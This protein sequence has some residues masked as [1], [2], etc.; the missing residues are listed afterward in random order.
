MKLYK[1][2][3][4]TM[5]WLKIKTE[6]KVFHKTLMNNYSEKCEN[7]VREDDYLKK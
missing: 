5:Y 4:S 3:H 6:C 7:V 1:I 2:I